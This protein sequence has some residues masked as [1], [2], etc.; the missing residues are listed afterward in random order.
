MRQKHFGGPI[1]E[2]YTSW[3]EL[4]EETQY[5]FPFSPQIR[6]DGFL[7]NSHSWV[8]PNALKECMK[9][10]EKQGNREILQALEEAKMKKGDGPK[11]KKRKK[12][13]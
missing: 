10:A 2:E 11:L 5:E 7:S 3:K 13:K 4:C 9:I 8:D 6:L 1:L 12:I